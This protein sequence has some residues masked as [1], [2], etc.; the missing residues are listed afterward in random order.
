[1]I[2]IVKNKSQVSLVAKSVS[3]IFLLL[4]FYWYY[5]H[6]A[7]KFQE[8][9]QQ[10]ISKLDIQKENKAKQKSLKIEKII[11]DE[12]KKVV[13]MINQ[14][15]VQSIKVVKNRL[16]IV[17]DYNTNIEPVMVRYGV[18][19]FVK[20]TNRNIKLAIDL[21]TIVGDRYGS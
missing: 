20:N 13:K 1:M 15:H 3:F 7:T 17:C 9:Q 2:I 8:K 10:L 5:N 16:L 11:Y 19:V 6:M 21:A 18:K 14:K 12:A 4:M